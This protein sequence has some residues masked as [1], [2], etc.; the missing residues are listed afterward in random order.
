[1]VI[2]I[3]P[4]WCIRKVRSNEESTRTPSR[5]PAAATMESACSWSD[6]LTTTSRMSVRWPV[7]TRSMAPMSPPTSPI[8]VVSWPRSPGMAESISTLRVTLYWALGVT[9]KGTP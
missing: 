7:P 2:S 5:P 4:P 9:A 3:L 1:M 8:A 6:A